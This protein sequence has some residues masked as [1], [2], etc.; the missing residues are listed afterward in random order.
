MEDNNYQT[1]GDSVAWGAARCVEAVQGK[2][3]V[4]PY[5]YG[6][7]RALPTG[8]KIRGL[9]SDYVV[10]DDYQNPFPYLEMCGT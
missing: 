5:L 10:F 6:Y 9:K 3:E 7:G 2:S 4:I 1:I 8:E